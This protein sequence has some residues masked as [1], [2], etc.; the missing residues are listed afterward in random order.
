MVH[1]VHFF[2]RFA[3]NSNPPKRAA[4]EGVTLFG[5]DHFGR[6]LPHLW[7]NLWQ[8]ANYGKGN[9]FK[10]LQW[11]ES[12]GN[13]WGNLLEMTVGMTMESM[14]LGSHYS[15]NPEFGWNFLSQYLKGQIQKAYRNAERLVKYPLVN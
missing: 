5:A 12:I 4:C 9:S 3:G 7:K 11:V 6:F 13:L 2:P 15:R 1:Y 8:W 14:E 10:Y